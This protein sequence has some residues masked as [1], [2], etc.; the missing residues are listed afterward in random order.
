MKAVKESIKRAYEGGGTQQRARRLLSG[1]ML[2]VMEEVG[3]GV[4]WIELTLSYLMLLRGSD[5]FAEDFG[6]VHAVY[7]MSGK[8]VAFYARER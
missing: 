8:D 7:C 6:G 1:N 3:R 4:A 5:L 2:R